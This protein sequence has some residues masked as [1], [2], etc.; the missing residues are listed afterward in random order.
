M[1]KL[2]IGIVAQQEM[3]AAQQAISELQDCKNRY[4]A[5]S[6]NGDTLQPGLSPSIPVF[7]PQWDFL[8]RTICL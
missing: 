1:Q 4:W 6:L 2:L 8:G 5:I 7:C 3:A